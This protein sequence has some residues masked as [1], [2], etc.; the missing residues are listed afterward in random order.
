MGCFRENDVDGS[1]S[2]DAAIW[3]KHIVPTCQCRRFWRSA[4]SPDGPR[5]GQPNDCVA[6][7]GNKTIIITRSTTD[8]THESR[9]AYSRI[10]ATGAD[11]LSAQ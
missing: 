11:R 7:A 3:T 10:A 9:K 5:T 2:L 4:T 8:D 1:S 6:I